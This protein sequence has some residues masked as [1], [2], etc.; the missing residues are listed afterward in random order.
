MNVAQ[1]LQGKFSV[2][3]RW[4]DEFEQGLGIV[5]GNPGV[6]Q[7]GAQPDWVWCLCQLAAPSYAQAF[8]LPATRDAAQDLRRTVLRE[9]L[10]RIATGEFQHRKLFLFSNG[11]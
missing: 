11:W 6:R 10:N 4:R 2:L 9:L 7:F 5:G 3:R 1:K 8:P